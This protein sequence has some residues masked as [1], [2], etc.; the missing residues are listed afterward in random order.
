MRKR[1]RYRDRFGAIRILATVCLLVAA[2]PASAAE[3]VF[4]IEIR[5]GKVPEA[6]RLIRVDEGDTVRLRWRSD[7]SI[8]VHLHGYDIERRI[9]PGGVAEMSFEATATG[10]FSI[11]EHGHGADGHRHGPPLVRVEVRPR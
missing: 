7:R 2:A 10:R 3:R 1:L 4:D 5:A 6:Q 11:S 9:A 8:A